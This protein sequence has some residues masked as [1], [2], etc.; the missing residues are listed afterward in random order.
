MQDAL[1][2]LKLG[3]VPGPQQMGTFADIQAAVG[4]PV[5]RRARLCLRVQ[6]SVCVWG[7]V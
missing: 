2:G 6:V 3:R 7:G 4:F 5:R 1:G